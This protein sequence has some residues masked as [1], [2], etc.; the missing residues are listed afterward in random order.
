MR[1][2]AS[3]HGVADVGIPADSSIFDKEQRDEAPTNNQDGIVG[4]VLALAKYE[5][6]DRRDSVIVAE[7]DHRVREEEDR[8]KN[9]HRSRQKSH[10]G[11]E[12]QATGNRTCRPVLGSAPYKGSQ[13]PRGQRP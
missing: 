1:P 9:C 13:D 5:F 8:D 6:R 11:E 4:Y 3:R 10:S 7:P 12:A 2:L